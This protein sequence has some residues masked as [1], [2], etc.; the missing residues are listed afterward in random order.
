MHT[1]FMKE[2]L[3]FVSVVIPECCTL[4]FFLS[5]L[6]WL[7]LYSFL[8][9]AQVCTPS[10]LQ[11]DKLGSQV[12]GF[13]CDNLDIGEETVLIFYVKSLTAADRTFSLKV[14][15]YLLTKLS[16]FTCT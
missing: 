7:M 13:T 16:L 12:S 14:R 3:F 5:Q 8:N 6:P 4:Y 10:S 2:F 11:S 1:N 15:K 9:T